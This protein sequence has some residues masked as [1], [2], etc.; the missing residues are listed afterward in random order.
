MCD[1][2]LTLIVKNNQIRD[3]RNSVLVVNKYSVYTSKYDSVFFLVDGSEKY[4]HKY[5][6]HMRNKDFEILQYGI[7]CTT[8]KHTLYKPSFI[9]VVMCIAAGRASGVP[10]PCRAKA[11]MC[12][13]VL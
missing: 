3:P 11:V 12:R 5:H 9:C 6:L 2:A 4:V 13:A 10:V 8:V 1:R 7:S